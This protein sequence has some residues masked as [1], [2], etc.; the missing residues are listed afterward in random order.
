MKR[1]IAA[2]VRAGY[3]VITTAA[4][5]V[6]PHLGRSSGILLDQGE[7]RLRRTIEAWRIGQRWRSLRR[8]FRTDSRSS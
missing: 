7:R 2:L 4:S 1:S 5:S 8:H 6:D 3:L